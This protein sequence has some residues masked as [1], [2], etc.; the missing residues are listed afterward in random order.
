MKLRTIK[1]KAESAPELLNATVFSPQTLAHAALYVPEGS[2][3][4]YAF[5]D[6][7]YQYANIK[8]FVEEKEQIAE[9]KGYTL[10]DENYQFAVYDKLNDCIRMVEHYQVDEQNFSTSW[11]MQEIEGKTYLYNL[12]AEKY[13]VR[14]ADGSLSLT[15][16]PT[17]VEVENVV[18]GI[19]INDN[20]ATWN[21]VK[22]EN[23]YGVKS[24]EEDVTGII[25]VS[26]DNAK[27]AEIYNLSGQRVTRD[28]K[29]IVIQNGKKI[30]VK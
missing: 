7:W 4:G 11:T 28:A 8:E 17:A 9:T 6:Y 26:E 21:F 16:I 29:G 14:G 19:R 23:I 12:G 24:L 10:M 25:S 20:T 1:C 27:D 18:D 5:D 22:N 2:W 30:L 13:V 15:T 3:Y